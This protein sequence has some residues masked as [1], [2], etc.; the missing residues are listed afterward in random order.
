[1]LGSNRDPKELY[2]GVAGTLAGLQGG[3][4]KLP[5]WTK[6]DLVERLC[7]AQP[8]S[9]SSTYRQ[10]QRPGSIVIASHERGGEAELAPMRFLL[11]VAFE[12]EIILGWCLD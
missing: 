5:R 10:A 4:I 3:P 12:H 8:R 9:W 6:P 2:C 11:P 7:G 1:M